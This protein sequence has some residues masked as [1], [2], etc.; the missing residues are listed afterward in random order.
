MAG[1]TVPMW[2]KT[3]REE[4]QPGTGF[5]HR[6]GWVVG[7]G[8][9]PAKNRWQLSW[10]EWPQKTMWVVYTLH[11]FME[12]IRSW[13]SCKILYFSLQLLGLWRSQLRIAPFTCLT[14]FLV[15]P[16]SL[17]TITL[18]PA[19]ICMPRQQH[20]TQHSGQWGKGSM[21]QL[22]VSYTLI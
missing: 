1:F 8:K 18:V 7:L 3:Q 2:R 4:M 17:L 13:L 15:P 20:N 19:S 22:L 9:I 12:M 5:H 16:P 6:T 10:F 11:T 21:F 14:W